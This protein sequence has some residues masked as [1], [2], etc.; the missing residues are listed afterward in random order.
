MLCGRELGG[1]NAYIT[2]VCP[3]STDIR[4][5]GI[6]GGD[7]AGRACWVIV[8][9]MCG[10]EVQGTFEQKMKGCAICDFYALVREEEHIEM[11]RTI[12]LLELVNKNMRHHTPRSE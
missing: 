11:E 12:I 5:D 10:G 9:T 8:G 2:G 7:N 4:F 6:H 3:A 1:T